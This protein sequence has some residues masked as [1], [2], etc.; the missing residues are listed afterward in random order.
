MGIFDFFKKKSKVNGIIKY[1]NL[2]T[3]WLNELSDEERIA[4]L[5]TYSSMGS[6]NSIIEGEVYS[7]SQTQLHFFWGLIGW[8]NKPELRYIAYK[9]ITKAETLIDKNSDPLDVHFLYGTKLEICYKDR[10]LRPNGLELAIQ[11]CEQQ[12]ENAPSAAIS[13]KQKYGNDLPAHKG[14]YQLAIV[15]EK[16]KRYSEAIHLCEKAEFQGWA[17]DW[18]KR[19]ERC[20]KRVKA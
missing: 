13:F 10:D 19:I 3:W 8:F 12:I 11:A 1:L 2:E 18:E 7:S 9:L 6:E 4:I 20:N 5:N 17:G 16:Q 14:Y 15:L